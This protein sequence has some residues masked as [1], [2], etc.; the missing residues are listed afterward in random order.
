MREQLTYLYFN[1]K[2]IKSEYRKPEAM[3]KVFFSFLDI[4]ADTISAVNNLSL[5]P[6][7][8]AAAWVGQ[9]PLGNWWIELDGNGTP[10]LCTYAAEL[11]PMVISA[12]NAGFGAYTMTAQ[13][14]IG[15]RPS[16]PVGR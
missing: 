8:T 9:N 7:V 3:G 2:Q 4:S 5:N 13:D 15:G 1:K 10:V 16:R 12:S 6:P 11:T 14:F